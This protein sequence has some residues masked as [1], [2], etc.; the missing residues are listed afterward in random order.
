MSAATGNG[1]T[2][3][4]ASPVRLKFQKGEL[5]FKEGSFGNCLYAV[6][7]GKINLF[8]QKGDREIPFASLGAGEIFGEIALFSGCTV[9]NIYTCRAGEDSILELRLAASVLKELE[10]LPPLLREIGRQTLRRLYAARVKV[11]QLASSPKGAKEQDEQATAQK[12][13]EWANQQRRH[14]RK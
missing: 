6:I 12:R 13:M 11:S 1:K 10:E 4:P 9:P 14:Y 5:I 8:K 2:N 3:T 7:E